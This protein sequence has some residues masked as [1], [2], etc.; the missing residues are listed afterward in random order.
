M[1]C[2][3]CECCGEQF[4]PRSKRGRFCSRKCMQRVADVKYREKNCEKLKEKVRE[5]KRNNPEYVSAALAKWR[6][7]NPEKKRAICQKSRVKHIQREREQDIIRSRQK[8]HGEKIRKLMQAT[9][10][11]VEAANGHID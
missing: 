9:Q 2:R 6:S 10:K 4:Q 3:S 5:W 1:E 8:R 11:L 7:E